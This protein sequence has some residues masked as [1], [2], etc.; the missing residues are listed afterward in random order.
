MGDISPMQASCTESS[1]THGGRHTGKWWWPALLLYLPHFVCNMFT[2]TFAE[3][4]S[5]LASTIDVCACCL[6]KSMVG[7]RVYHTVM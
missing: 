5:L 6:L 7:M 3:S 1:N 2:L 4:T